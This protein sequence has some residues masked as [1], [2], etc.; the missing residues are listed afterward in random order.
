MIF[1]SNILSCS[2]GANMLAFVPISIGEI[3]IMIVIVA[4]VVAIVY[5]ALRQFGITIPGW[6]IQVFW[7]IVVCFVC[8]LAIKLVISM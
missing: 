4:A 6:V 7:I 8:I 5:V 2:E 3:A 1:S